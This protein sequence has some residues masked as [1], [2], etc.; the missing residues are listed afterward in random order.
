MRATEQEFSKAVQDA[1]YEIKDKIRLASL[2][3]NG[4]T[5]YADFYSNSGKQTWTCRFVYDG[6]N[7]HHITYYPGTGSYRTANGP[8][9]FADKII[10]CL[11]R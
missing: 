2:G 9:F 7:D 5:A 4:Y 6:K 8:K 10:E 11:E 1:Y 3:V